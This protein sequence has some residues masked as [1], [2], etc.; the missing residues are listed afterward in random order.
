[1]N[2]KLVTTKELAKAIGVTARRV[3]QMVEEHL[4][5]P[6]N[7]EKRFELERCE[8]RY[9]LYKH[10]SVTQW[11]CYLDEVEAAGI[12]SQEMFERAMEADAD[13][14]IKPAIQAIRRVHEDL[15]FLAVARSKTT[16]ESNLFLDM[17]EQQEDNAIGA[18]LAHFL[19]NKTWVG[20]DGK[21]I[22][23]GPEV[24]AS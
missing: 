24:R 14:L 6:P 10:G 12:A 21:V 7:A 13:D 18:L 23:R 5:P 15:R 4:M 2:Q 16:A 22:Y 8:L 9:R 20:D 11:N 19:R 3:G 1:M 17:W